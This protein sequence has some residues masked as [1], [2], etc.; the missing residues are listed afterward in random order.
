MVIKSQEQEKG[1]A[2]EGK[3]P[4]AHLHEALLLPTAL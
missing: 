2:R 3:L 1:R 4:L